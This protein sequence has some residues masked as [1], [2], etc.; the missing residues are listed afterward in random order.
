MSRKRWVYINGEAIEVSPDFVNERTV[1]AADSVLWNDR[2]Y[3]DMGDPRFA[4]RKQH[5]EYMKRNG[6]TTADDFTNT[7]QSAAKDRER[8]LKGIDPT[9]KRDIAEAFH[10]VRRGR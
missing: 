6:L 10:R 7:W 5:R 3:Q 8:A 2:S 1:T 4:S 9:R